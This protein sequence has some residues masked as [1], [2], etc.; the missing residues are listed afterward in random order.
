MV[1]KNFNR[2][3]ISLSVLLALFF[4]C[5]V[6]LP[7]SLAQVEMD[8][9][10]SASETTAV[11]PEE[12][13]PPLPKPGNVTVNFKDVG[14]KTVLL[15][16]SEVSGVDI[17]PSPGVEGNVTMRLRDKPWELALDIVTRNYGYV[18]SREENIIRVIPKGKLQT[19]EPLT[20]VIPLNYVTS[21]Y[22]GT[23]QNVDRLMEA[24]N[25]VLV[26]D[27][28]EKA[29]FLPNANA[30][31]VTAIPSRVGTVREMVA[32][33][34]KKTPQI[35]LEARVLE[36]T[37]DKTDQFGIDW[38][39]VITT[40]GARRPTTLPFTGAGVLP[41]LPGEEQ[42][43]YLPLS[44]TAPNYVSD[45]VHLGV[46]LVDPTASTVA[47]NALNLFSYGTLDF[48]QLS[49]TLRL[50]NEWDDTNIISAPRITTL[51]NQTAFIK[52]ITNLFLQ[53]QQKASDTATTITVEFETKAREVGVTLKVTP[54]VNDKGEISVNLEP[55]VSSDITFPT[56]T[57]AGNQ[58]TQ[59]LRYNTRS[60]QT[61][62][63]VDDGETIFIG[64]LISET[65]TKQDH[66][67][68]ILGDLFGGIPVIGNVFKYEQDNVDKTEVVFFVTV[69][70]IKDGAYSIK[71][72]KTEEEF[73]K[74][75]PEKADI[76]KDEAEEMKVPV[77][78]QGKM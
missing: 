56:I 27:T 75:F 62:V 41:F 68:P 72:S 13:K 46:Q 9:D 77:V 47:T 33:I 42:R 63:M 45:F 32:K 43:K 50:I 10:T 67:L 54:H 65:R 51:N 49:A 12:V 19:E 78:K 66:K 40:A 5:M 23:G 38:N 76:L 61:Q 29:T 4:S 73:K 3:T 48:S 2:I 36:I 35:M 25:S 18:Y 70:I 22:E 24:I 1:T 69:H 30:I 58:E 71:K 26:A 7:D 64:G 20:E 14:I 74:H 28:G 59:A 8:M 57:V 52:V 6:L 34:D 15:Y 21:T 17:V 37:L 39:A 60:A 16:L 53:K 44:G 31:V 55:E 11:I